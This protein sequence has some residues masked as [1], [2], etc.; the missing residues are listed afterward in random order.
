MGVTGPAPMRE[1]DLARPRTRGQG[2][3]AP[4]VTRGELLEVV[5]PATPAKWHG[6]AKKLFD[7]VKESGQR[8]FMQNSDWALLL[9][10]CDDLSRYKRAEDRF[11]TLERARDKWHALTTDERRDAGLD[12]FSPPQAPG[13]GGSAMKLQA[14]LSALVP[15]GMT[16]GDRRRMHIELHKPA[17]QLIDAS[18]TAI[19]DYKNKLMR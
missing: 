4:Q 16:E 18:V 19:D 17:P 11:E 8:Q 12:P 14:T 2:A 6:I 15:F 1:G 13:R 10:L 5:V 9:S 7:G 3:S